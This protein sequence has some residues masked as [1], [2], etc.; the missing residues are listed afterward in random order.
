MN[1]NGIHR[2]CGS[3]NARA[4]RRLGP[5]LTYGLVL[6]CVCALL[7]SSAYGTTPYVIGD[8][9]ASNGNPPN[10]TVPVQIVGEQD[11][12]WTQVDQCGHFYAYGGNLCS[13][14]DF[15]CYVTITIEGEARTRWVM[16]TT[17]DFGDWVIA[18]TAPPPPD[19]DGD[20]YSVC[21]DDCNDNIPWIN[22][23]APEICCNSWDENCNGQIDDGCPVCAD[24][25]G[26][27]YDICDDGDCNDNN[28]SIHP[29]AVERCNG[30]D[31]DCDGQV[32]ERCP[33]LPRPRI[34][35]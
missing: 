35:P 25:D 31:D 21:D 14:P 27:G 13:V 29:N 7:P 19:N 9:E 2:D 17:V 24:C 3:R 8:V 4:T 32:D 26:D 15:G 10:W 34:E 18:G 16:M 30:I 23:G 12:I 22:P 5:P 1:T 33:P 6:A 20:G 28:S 11:V